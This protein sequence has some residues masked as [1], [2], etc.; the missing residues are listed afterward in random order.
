MTIPRPS[1]T[2]PPRAGRAVTLVELLVTMGVLLVILTLAG[3]I[4][5]E[6]ERVSKKIVR[7]QQAVQYCQ[8]AMD[9]ALATVAAAVAPEAVAA[10]AEGSE[11]LAPSFSST[12]LSVLAFNHDAPPYLCRM[13]LSLNNEPGLPPRLVRQVRPIAAFL[14]NRKQA[15][16]ERLDDLGGVPPEDR[17]RPT[18]NFRYAGTVEPGR[19]PAYV[20]EWT[21]GGLP[22]LIQISI[23]G[24]LDTDPG[25]EIHLETAVIPGLLPKTA[26][27]APA[28]QLKPGPAAAAG[29]AAPSRVAPA[30]PP[31]SI[32][33]EVKR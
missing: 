4:M 29:H 25:H 15:V 32:P 18:M 16:Q 13:T 26:R 20:D 14:G 21:S 6:S 24:K 1:R 2:R 33:R 22:A 12:Q 31:T 3:G 19:M 11:P 23:G 28:P 27:P 5:V 30:A 9:Q 17:F 7:Y 8:R 10:P